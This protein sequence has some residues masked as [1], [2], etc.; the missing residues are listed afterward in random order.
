MVVGAVLDQEGRPIC[1][2][3]TICGH[4]FC[5]FLALVLLKDLQ[6]RMKSRPGGRG[7][8]VEWEYLKR[9]LE[10]LQETTVN[11]AGRTFVIRNRP[12]GEVAKALQAAGVSLGPTVRFCE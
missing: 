8:P 6:G 9:D 2:E 3:L 7:E 1:C 5:S 12:R 10:A 11:N 4:V